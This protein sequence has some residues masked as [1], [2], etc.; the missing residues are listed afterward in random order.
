MCLCT[1][2][3]GSWKLMLTVIP[4]QMP[5]TFSHP[6]L[7]LPLLKKRGYFSATG[8]IIGSIAPD[9]ESFV[10]ITG[11]KIYSH[12]WPGIFWFDLPL[13]LLLSFLFHVIVREPLVDNL[14]EIFRSRL[15]EYKKINWASNFLKKL[16]VLLF[17]LVLGIT[18]HLLFDAFTH[19]NLRYPDDTTSRIMVGHTR[20]YIIIQYSSSVVGLLI[21]RS[22]ILKMPKERNVPSSG[23]I[24]KFWLYMVLIG[25]LVGSVLCTLTIERN[26]FDP[27][28]LINIIMASFFSTLLLVTSFLKVRKISGL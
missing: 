2:A 18:S 4:L 20:L 22:A 16:L 25:T 1:D 17:S 28:I 8:L 13:A 9:F 14:P 23:H 6:V 10:K 19:L 27:I 15:Q 11:P 24:F 5:F 12:T 7:V 3:F 21:L 26:T